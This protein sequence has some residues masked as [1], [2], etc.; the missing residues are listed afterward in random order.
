VIQE[1]EDDME[2]EYLEH[3]K[4]LE[5][6][7]PESSYRVVVEDEEEDTPLQGSQYSSEGEEYEL[8]EDELYSHEVAEDGEYMLSIWEIS[9][10]PC[11]SSRLVFISSIDDQ[12]HLTGN[13]NPATTI[14]KSQTP[15]GST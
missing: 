4:N 3:L 13:R 7:E 1:E 5:D 15:S 6:P 11:S 2:P 8:G 9:N 12:S 14:R 10:E